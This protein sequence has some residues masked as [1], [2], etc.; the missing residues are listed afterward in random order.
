[1]LQKSRAVSRKSRKSGF[2]STHVNDIK[3]STDSGGTRIVFECYLPSST[4]SLA[5]GSFQISSAACPV[6]THT[7]QSAVRKSVTGR[8]SKDYEPYKSELQNFFHGR[9]SQDYKSDNLQCENSVTGRSCKDNGSRRMELQNLIQGMPR[10][11]RKPSCNMKDSKISSFRPQTSL[12]FFFRTML[13][14]L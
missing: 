2:A 6:Q 3:N 9:S 4:M 10:Q 12:F 1:M 14:S 8:L 11:D 7:W 13:R 5:K